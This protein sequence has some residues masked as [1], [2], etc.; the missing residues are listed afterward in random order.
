MFTFKIT[1]Y[2]NYLFI[3]HSVVNDKR[4][5][6][7]KIEIDTLYIIVIYNMKMIIN[8]VIKIGKE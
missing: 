8:I 4:L 6:L 5:T 2:V 3:D 1:Y 7:T